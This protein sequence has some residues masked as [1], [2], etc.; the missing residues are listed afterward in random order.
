MAVNIDRVYQTVLTLLNKE[1]RGFLPP[2]EFNELAQ[3]AQVEIFET[4]FFEL[5]RAEAQYGTM[6]AEYGN[7]ADHIFEKLE[8]FETTTTLIPNPEGV[9]ELPPT[10]YRLQ[11]LVTASGYDITMST[12]KDIGYILRAPLTAPVATQPLYVRTGNAIQ[13]YPTTGIAGVDVHYIENL[14]Q[15]RLP[16]WAGV[17]IDG[18]LVQNSSSINFQLHVSEEPELVAKILGYAGVVVKAPDVAQAGAV[19]TASIQQNEQ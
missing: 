14:D 15:E 5:G 16:R 7:I 17:I 18:Q 12:H 19:T 1:Q 2:D 11:T 13:V 10:L 8:A 9:F 4:Y 3:Q 6:E